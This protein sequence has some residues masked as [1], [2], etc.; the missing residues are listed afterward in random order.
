MYYKEAFF[1]SWFQIQ[2]SS[3]EEIGRINN[4][5]FNS[6]FSLKIIKN[7]FLGSLKPHYG[8]QP[9]IVSLTFS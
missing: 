5:F 2:L 8:I 4:Q 9:Q 1:S 7:D 6:I 3:I